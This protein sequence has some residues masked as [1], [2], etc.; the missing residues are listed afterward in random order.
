MSRVNEVLAK[1]EQELGPEGTIEMHEEVQR[2]INDANPYWIKFVLTLP[3]ILEDNPSHL[4]LL[5]TSFMAGYLAARILTED[6]H[7]GKREQ[8]TGDGES[9]V[10]LTD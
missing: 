4:E 7:V 9:P 1:L 6:K 2:D 8:S 3:T 5:K 10:W